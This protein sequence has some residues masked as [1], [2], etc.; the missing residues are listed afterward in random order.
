MNSL[1]S[2]NDYEEEL[3]YTATNTARHYAASENVD[4]NANSDSL[5]AGRSLK[6][7]HG[8]RGTD[9]S[10]GHHSLGYQGR[11][12]SDLE[13][14]RTYPE[15]DRPA[16]EARRPLNVDGPGSIPDQG[17]SRRDFQPPYHASSIEHVTEGFSRLEFPAPSN[18]RPQGGAAGQNV[19]T[20]ELGR[21][22]PAPT[23]AAAE[24]SPTGTMPSPTK[25]EPNSTLIKGGSAIRDDQLDKRKT[26]ILTECR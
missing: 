1:L 13:R 14:S 15:G 24:T 9:T 21:T 19:L 25:E 20:N 10:R 18:Q 4:P 16:M 8:P 3:H 11:E 12:G 22:H 5:I 26:P 17:Q 23:G 6:R 7:A 2:P